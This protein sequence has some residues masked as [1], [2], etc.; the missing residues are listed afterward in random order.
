LQVLRRFSPR[1]AALITA[2]L[3][4]TLIAPGFATRAHAT[5]LA[6][7]DGSIRELFE[8]IRSDENN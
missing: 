5:Y 2:A 1:R 6:I 8:E 3:A 4:V 7:V